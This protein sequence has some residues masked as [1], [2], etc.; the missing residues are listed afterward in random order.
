MV[1]QNLGGAIRVALAATIWGAAYPLTKMILSD[2]PPIF[3]GFLRFA[4]A[5]AFFM[6]FTGKRPLNG[7]EKDEITTFLSLAFWGVFVLILGM[8]F[9]LI[10]A[11]GMAASIIS[12]TPPL[13]TIIL[14]AVFLKERVRLTQVFSIAVAISGIV[15][16]GGDFSTSV[17][18]IEDWKIWIGCLLTLIPQFA[19]AMYGILGKKLIKKHHWSKIC[20]DTFSLGALMLFPFALAEVYLQGFGNWDQRSVLVLVYLAFMNSVITYSLWNSALRLIPVSVASFLIY[21]Q[22]VSGAILSYIMFGEEIGKKGLIG[23]CL[24]FIALALIMKEEK[25]EP[26][27][28]QTK[29]L[30]SN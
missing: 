29:V 7:I 3:L 27:N 8:N 12:G 5:A 18:G 9:G 19:W 15:L 24:I 25:K 28:L 1:S 26:A 22:P 10:W 30:L 6:A 14:A 4:L 23:T 20:R 17:K 16:L 11:P 21:L 2:I 13:F